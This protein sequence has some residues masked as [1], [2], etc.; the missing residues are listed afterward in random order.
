[1]L[2]SEA[3]RWISSSPSATEGHVELHDGKCFL[4]LSLSQKQLRRIKIRVR[5]KYFEVACVSAGTSQAREPHGVCCRISLRGYFYPVPTSHL[6]R[7]RVLQAILN[8][9]EI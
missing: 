6:L 9:I 7:N 2:E 1:M 8:G 4:L 3:G 5:G